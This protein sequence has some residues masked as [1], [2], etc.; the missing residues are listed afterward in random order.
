MKIATIS[1]RS[2]LFNNLSND[3]NFVFFE[4][5][6]ELK[7]SKRISYLIMDGDELTSTDLLTIRDDFPK[8]KIILLINKG[9]DT[10]FEKACITH[11]IVTISKNVDSDDLKTCLETQWFD[12]KSDPENNVIA[13]M[14]THSQ[15]GVTHTA[16][17]IA[18]VMSEYNVRAVVIG[19]NPYNPGI[20]PKLESKP[21]LDQLYPLL[22]SGAVVDEKG[23]ANFLNEID[24]FYYLPGNTDFYRSPSY[25][26]EPVEDLVQILK[27]VYDYVILDCGSFYDNFLPITG[28]R[29]A[30]THL[31]IGSQ[32]Y[33]SINL[34]KTW[35]ARILSKI[36]IQAKT[37][38][39]IL[40]KYSSG[41]LLT[42]KYIQE[43]IQYP[44]LG[45]LPYVPGG[46]DDVQNY[47]LLINGDFKPYYK[48]SVKLT[49]AILN[50]QS[51]PKRTKKKSLFAVFS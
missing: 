22:E 34:F 28:L 50:K 37:K 27:K 12:K 2:E 1:K 51:E 13:I 45:H 4:N 35:E 39:M 44:I 38:H 36:N 8:M 11:D 26:G 31:L 18:K 5:I 24:G 40:N 29:I 43:R 15:V 14:G 30:D 47:N 16:L 25:K 48:A 19:L 7:K 32:E 42:A 3:F 46:S 10:F 21:T 33:D 6:E 9:E 41:A 17:S 49:K 20:V 23:I